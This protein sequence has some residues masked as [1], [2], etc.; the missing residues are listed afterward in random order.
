MFTAPHGAVCAAMLPHA[1]AVNVRALRERTPGG[2]A[3][4][5]FDEV[6]RLLT[7][8]RHA[9]AADGVEWIAQLCRRL[10]IPRLRTYGVS[11]QD[12]PALVEKA[13]KASSMKG[14]PIVLNPDELREIIAEAI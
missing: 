6:A 5:R 2:N 12:V 4:R 11:D 7:G 8:R 3:L 10:E 1:M 13:A 14:N 9:A